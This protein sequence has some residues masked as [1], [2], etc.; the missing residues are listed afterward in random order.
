MDGGLTMCPQATK[1]NGDAICGR[2]IHVRLLLI[3][4]A[5]WPD[6][7]ALLFSISRRSTGRKELQDFSYWPIAAIPSCSHKEGINNWN[8]SPGGEEKR[9]LRVL[10]DA[11]SDSFTRKHFAYAL[12]TVCCAVLLSAAHRLLSG[13]LANLGA[14]IKGVIAGFCVRSSSPPCGA[15]EYI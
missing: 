8:C 13:L 11:K 14:L 4:G 10:L 9:Y 3:S 15:V 6:G 7:R 5:G 2:R 1:L 12:P